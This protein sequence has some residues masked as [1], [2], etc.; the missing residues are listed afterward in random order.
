MREVDPRDVGDDA[1]IIASEE[2]VRGLV[3]RLAN[4][5]D[6]PDA[7]P[8]I[9]ALGRAAIPALENFLRGPSQALHH[10]RVLAADALAAI[11]GE[12]ACAALIRSLRDSIARQPMPLAREAEDV[13]VSR[14]A[15]HLHR[16]RGPSVVE[17][18]LDALRARPYPA[19]ARV[20]GEFGDRRAVPLLIECLSEDAAREAAM[21]SVRRFGAFAREPLRDFLNS[22]RI[23]DGM[24]PPSRIDGRAAA[25]TLLA[26]FRDRAALESVLDDTQRP[27]RLAAAVGLVECGGRVDR[28]TLDTLLQGLDEPDWMRAEAIMGALERSREPVAPALLEILDQSSADAAGLRRQR[29]AAELAARM[30]LG[31]ARPRLMALYDAADP[32]LRLAAVDALARID[33]TEPRHLAPFLGDDRIGVA[34]QALAAMRRHGVV[35]LRDLVTEI[36]R[37]PG[38][39]SSPGRWRRTLH[40]LVAER[41]VQARRCNR[42]VGNAR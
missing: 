34:L 12:E 21:W 38:G 8:E 23:T 9:V 18:L 1:E 39:K 29:R 27:V 31:Q 37:V 14:I 40:L 41:W 17:A 2:C 33:G 20:L 35:H 28:R 19:C 26:D 4:L 42:P 6:G 13:V 7:I 3:A 25:A 32:A 30:N 5:R 36:G 15:D 24:E 16:F 10:S 22:P 11:G